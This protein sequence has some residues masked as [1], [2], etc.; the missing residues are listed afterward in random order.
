MKL[1]IC[2]VGKAHAY[3]ARVET[4]PG[5]LE[6]AVTVIDADCTIIDEFI[7]RYEPG[8]TWKEMKQNISVRVFT[9]Y[10]A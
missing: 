2:K 6:V 7:E 5:G 8:L 1:Y 9:D 10:V 3:T 4:L